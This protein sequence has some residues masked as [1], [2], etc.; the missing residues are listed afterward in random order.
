M[1]CFAPVKPGHC[2][3]CCLSR[4]TASDAKRRAGKRPALV[5]SKRTLSAIPVPIPVVMVPVLV[6]I[7]DVDTDTPVIA[8]A[9]PRA[10]VRGV[11]AGTDHCNRRRL[12]D[13]DEVAPAATECEPDDCGM[14]SI[15]T[16][17]PSITPS[18]APPG[19]LLEPV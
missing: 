9:D 12:R 7:I 13:E 18:T 5:L 1:V 16:L 10:Y 6:D 8:T 4:I 14:V 15:N 19:C 17:V 3:L 11:T 2:A